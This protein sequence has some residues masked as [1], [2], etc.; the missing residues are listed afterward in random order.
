VF[1]TPNLGGI[2]W[3]ERL[4]QVFLVVILGLTL[5]M[6]SRS[7]S[8]NSTSSSGTANADGTSTV[9]VSSLTTISQSMFCMNVTYVNDN[10]EYFGCDATDDTVFGTSDSG[11]S[12]AI[13][14]DAAFAAGWRIVGSACTTGSASA[15]GK[16]VLFHK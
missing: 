6:C 1:I 8:N 11:S 10:I 2:M 15:Y 16:C 7:S 12:G 9:S 13:S 3:K 14:H 4:W 5:T